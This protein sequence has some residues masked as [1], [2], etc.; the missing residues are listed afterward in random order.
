MCYNIP[1]I[2]IAIFICI[3]FSSV[4]NLLMCAKKLSHV[5]IAIFSQNVYLRKV[6]MMRQFLLL[7][8]LEMMLSMLAPQ[9]CDVFYGTTQFMCPFVSKLQQKLSFNMTTLRQNKTHR[10]L[11][12]NM[13]VRSKHQDAGMKWVPHPMQVVV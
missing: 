10:N 3:G 6:S 13:F 5:N 9:E 12:K 4:S 11:Q 7:F 2:D 1:Y 8:Q